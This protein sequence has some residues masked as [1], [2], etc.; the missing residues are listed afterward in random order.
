MRT[1]DVKMN[2]VDTEVLLVYKSM[3]DFGLGETMVLFGV[4]VDTMDHQ[5]AVQ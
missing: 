4:N 2:D 5:L 1:E 3:S